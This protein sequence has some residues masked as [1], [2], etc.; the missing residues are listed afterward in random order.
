MDRKMKHQ[1]VLQNKYFGIWRESRLSK[2]ML[3]T[4]KSK[5]Q[6]LNQF[7]FLKQKKTLYSLLLFNLQ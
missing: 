5:I 3:N 2:L 1:S 6:I 7:L 4:S